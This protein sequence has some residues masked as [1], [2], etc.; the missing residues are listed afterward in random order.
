MRTKRALYIAVATLLVAL[1]LVAATV[2][3]GQEQT[4][5]AAITEAQARAI[6]L[7]AVPGT[8][9]EVELEREGGRSLYEVEVQPRAGG[10][11]VGVEIDAMTGVIVETEVEDDDDGPFDD[12][13][14]RFRGGNR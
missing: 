10:R 14:E 7:N 8:V 4:P 9:V 3:F 12:F 1:S 2:A 11:V 13:F 6:A 5:T